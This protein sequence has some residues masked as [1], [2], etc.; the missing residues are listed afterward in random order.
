[1]EG[2]KEGRGMSKGRIVILG[3]EL[4]VAEHLTVR[5]RQKGYE[6]IPALANGEQAITL[7]REIL[8]DLI[9]L[10]LKLHGDPGSLNTARSVRAEFAIPVVYLS[11]YSRES[12]RILAA[13]D[14]SCQY[15]S[16]PFP[17]EELFV[18]IETA[19]A[20]RKEIEKQILMN[21]AT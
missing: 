14:E 19:L 2:G 10:D 21:R 20:N 8:P 17:E 11:V 15:V 6:V 1:M 7:I 13:L 4:I 3:N 5:L 18:V 12:L 9:L 16:K